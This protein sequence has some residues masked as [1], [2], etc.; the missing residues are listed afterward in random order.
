M[1]A[2]SGAASLR[3]LYGLGG[4]AQSQ[5]LAAPTALPEIEVV[6]PRIAQAPRPPK[7]HVT[8]GKPRAT[9]APPPTAPPAPVSPAA[10]LA[11]KSSV[12]D[13]ARS[14]IYTTVG[15]TSDTITHQT[16]QDLPQ[17][18]NQSV[19]RGPLQAPAA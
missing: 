15:T 1:L 12:F 9:P 11:A 6:K 17:G 18:D 3:L 7:T 16:I 5:V 14:N 4:S 10:Q 13:Q 19:G 8:S 2:A